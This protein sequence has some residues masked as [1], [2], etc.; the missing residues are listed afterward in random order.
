MYEY[1]RLFEKIPWMEEDF[2]HKVARIKH[3]ISRSRFIRNN[4][5]RGKRR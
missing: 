1:Y 5:K 4:R 3:K 2:H